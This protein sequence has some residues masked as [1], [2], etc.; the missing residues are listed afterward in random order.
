MNRTYSLFFRLFSTVNEI[1]KWIP[2]LAYNLDSLKYNLELKTEVRIFIILT[3]FMSL[4][5]PPSENFY[6]GVY[7]EFLDP[8]L[9][10][11]DRTWKNSKLSSLYRF[12]DVKNSWLKDLKRWFNRSSIEIFHAAPSTTVIVNWITNLRMQKAQE[13]E[14]NAKEYLYFLPK[15]L[16][17][18]L[19]ICC[20]TTSVYF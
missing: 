12:W 2:L 4:L 8:H 17:L 6:P 15:S 10:P 3:C 9:P 11:V 20:L 1:L 18:A 13:E 19:P 7:L 14:E 5:R 16:I